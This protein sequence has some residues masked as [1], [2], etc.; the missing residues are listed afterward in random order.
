MSIDKLKLIFKNAP[1][2]EAWS[3]QLLH[4][5]TSK[6]NG[7]TY[8]GREIEL[9][10][11]GKLSQFISEISNRYAN[12]TRGVL[13]FFTD[14]LEYDASVVGNVIYKMSTDNFLV[15]EEYEALISALSS[16]DYEMNPMEL[17]TQAYVLK[18]MVTVNDTKYP[19]KFI[20]M[21]N[22]FTTLKNKFMQSNGSFEEIKNKVL[23]LKTSIDVIII[24][25]VIYMLTFAAE[26][27][28]NMERA[29][30]AIC[31]QKIEE[32]KA[33]DILL[34]ND[35]FSNIASK[36]H[37]PR[38]FVS[39]NEKRLEKLKN[40]DNRQ[41][42]AKKFN[43]PLVSGKFDTSQEGTVE[44]IVKLLCNKGMLDPFDDIPVEVAGAKKWS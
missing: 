23:S 17:S 13:L 19:V 38:R 15:K 2:Y 37:N 41:Q 30:K 42:M 9:K 7:T 21:Q 18:G 20:S 32:I 26:K 16:P 44:K 4:I 35:I 10:P 24:D 34:D 8:L 3:I 1:K 14:V 6:R 28:F 11:T 33:C 39:F 31:V 40:N 22:P 29:Y 43:I 5:S 36:G 25:N 27:L 12:E